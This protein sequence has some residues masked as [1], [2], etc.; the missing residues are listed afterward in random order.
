MAPCYCRLLMRWGYFNSDALYCVPGN[1][2]HVTFKIGSLVAGEPITAEKKRLDHR[3]ALLG[4]VDVDFVARSDPQRIRAYTR[5]TLAACQ[6]GG[7]F[8]FGVGNWVVDS[9]PLENYLAMIDE[10]RGF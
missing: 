1:L 5:T 3:V 2:T 10:A 9:I 8:S 7:G 4:G 6:P